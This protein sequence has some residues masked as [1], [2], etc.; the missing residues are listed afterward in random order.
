MTEKKSAWSSIPAV[1]AG[2]ATILTATV[3]LV[4][5]IGGNRQAA[6][7][8]VDQSPSPT[9]TPSASDSAFP[10]P[11][12]GVAPRA[13]I[14]PKSLDFGQLGTGKSSQQKV[15]VTNTGNEYLVID[16]VTVSGRT[17][18]FT[19]DAQECSEPAGIAPEDTCEI[20]VTFSP[21]VTGSLAASMEVKHSGNTSPGT[22]ALNGEGRLLDL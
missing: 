15:S 10:V 2:I 12:G 16:E 19:A 9:P 4:S 22:V 7:P 11:T 14:A 1:V 17:D 3:A 21:R 8:Q 5:V 20:T 6:D 13:V 18:S